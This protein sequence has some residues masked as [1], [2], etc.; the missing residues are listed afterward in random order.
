VVGYV[1]KSSKNI[2][3]EKKTDYFE[4]WSLIPM[5]RISAFDSKEL[6]SENRKFF[7]DY[8]TLEHV[9][10]LWSAQQNDIRLYVRE[11]HHGFGERELLGTL[12]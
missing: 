1:C 7:T 11:V 5:V 6:L 4:D 9:R 8:S 3:L 10:Y 2:A 12:N